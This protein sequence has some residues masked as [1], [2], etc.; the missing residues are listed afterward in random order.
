LSGTVRYIK[1]PK[2]KLTLKITIHNCNFQGMIKRIYSDI[3]KKQLKL[4][5]IVTV[6]GPRQCGKTTFV[7][8]GLSS[9]KYVDCERPS[10]VTPLESDPEGRLRQLGEHVILDEAQMLPEL[11]PVLRSLVDEKRNSKGTLVLLGSASPQLIRNISESL[12][13][14]TG[15]IELTPFLISE[16]INSDEYEKVLSQ[17]W[18]RGG[19]PDAFLMDDESSLPLYFDAYVRTF[20]ERDLNRMG[21]DIS[22]QMMRKLWAMLAHTNSQVWNASRIAASLGVNYQTVNRYIDILEQAFLMRRLPPYFK[23]IGKRLTKSPKI[24]FRHSGLL[25]FFLGI[26]SVEVLNVHPARGESWESFVIEQL[27][28]LAKLIHPTCQAY[29]WRTH[30]GAEVDLL[31]DIGKTI[32]PFEIKLHSAPTRQMTKGLRS[33]MNDLE[34]P[35]GYIVYPGQDT[36]SLGNGCIAIGLKPLIESIDTLL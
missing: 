25:H 8:D 7:K 29:Y 21:I 34:L 26:E 16:V 28:A 5:P 6:L 22:P 30:A 33:C 24:L 14:R 31:L 35:K 12:T 20:V 19:L 23:N 11:F 4:F 13:G 3:F 1:T 36:Y 17:L 32:V 15:F 9:W 27:I 10:D 2:C 18:F